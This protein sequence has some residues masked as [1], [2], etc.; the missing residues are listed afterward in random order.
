MSTQTLRPVWRTRL[1]L[2]V[3]L[4][5]VAALISPTA[6]TQAQDTPSLT[7]ESNVSAVERTGA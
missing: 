4:L 2:F 1:L 7:I 5:L 6:S 3:L